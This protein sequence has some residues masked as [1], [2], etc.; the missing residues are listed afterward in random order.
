M[1]RQAIVLLTFLPLS[2][3]AGSPAAPPTCA[4][5][6]GSITS[7]VALPTETTTPAVAPILPPSN[8]S[9]D[10]PA[11]T[12]KPHPL[13]GAQP[14][15]GAG[16][17]RSGRSEA[18]QGGPEPAAPPLTGKPAVTT[19]S[20][21]AMTLPLIPASRIASEPALKL[22]ASHGAKLYAMPRLHGLQGVFARN[23]KHFGVFYVTPDGRAAIQGQM[24]SDHGR[25]LTLRQ[26]S[27]IPGVLPTVTVG[28]PPAGEK[29][30][31][32]LIVST[33]SLPAPA[34]A[35]TAVPGLPAARPVPKPSAAR[36]GRP[37]PASAEIKPSAATIRESDALV[38]MLQASSHGTIGRAKAPR[39]WMLVDPLCMYS[40]ETMHEM[41]PY[42]TAGKLR[43]SVVSLSVLDYEDHGASTAKA[44]VMV[45]RPK[46][47]MVTDWIGKGLPEPAGPHAAARL[48]ANMR[49][50]AAVRL[51]GTPTIL[52]RLPDGRFARI[53]GVP[54]SVP[55]LIR[56]ARARS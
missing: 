19:A 55:G 42:I 50:A 43:V 24:W 6:P 52:W 26:V 33:G 48:A 40:I 54:S 3:W 18:G 39:V 27:G 16:D 11:P 7:A 28:N 38:R 29:V 44:K 15:D 47:T 51:T 17:G 12:A 34:P 56:A 31:R 10:V 1:T 45:S 2:A 23:G 30:T 36:D 14:A 49:V 4:V 35:G 8:A 5:P 21:A 25:N 32:H 37:A 9:T 53:N 13:P 22:L 46:A 41:M 20:T